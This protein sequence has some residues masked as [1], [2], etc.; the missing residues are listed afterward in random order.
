MTGF[1]SPEDILLSSKQVTFA[2]LILT[3]KDLWMLMGTE[4]K[5]LSEGAEKAETEDPEHCGFLC[6]V[7]SGAL[8]CGPFPLPA[9]EGTI[10]SCCPLEATRDTAPC[11]TDRDE[12][13]FYLAS[14]P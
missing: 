9:G 6:G 5:D 14:I 1:Y 10:S 3:A 8:N 12:R 4:I 7:K 2:T 11:S 13:S